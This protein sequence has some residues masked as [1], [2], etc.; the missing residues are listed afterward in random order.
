MHPAVPSCMNVWNLLRVPALWCTG[1]HTSQ[2]GQRVW[3]RLSFIQKNVGILLSRISKGAYLDC[4]DSSSQIGAFHS[5]TDNMVHNLYCT[6]VKLAV[7]PDCRPPAR[8]FYRLLYSRS[9]RS[10]VLSDCFID[11]GRL[12]KVDKN[13]INFLFK[14]KSIEWRRDIDRRVGMPI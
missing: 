12:K 14:L 5:K 13:A 10:A 6:P 11:T 9:W 8:Y 7:N 4:M 1:M 2:Q 3:H